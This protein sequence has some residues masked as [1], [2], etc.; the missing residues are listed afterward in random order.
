QEDAFNEL[1]SFGYVTKVDGCIFYYAFGSSED[2]ALIGSRYHRDDQAATTATTNLVFAASVAA[3][4]NSYFAA[5]Q[6]KFSFNIE[7]NDLTYPA[8]LQRIIEDEPTW[9]QRRQS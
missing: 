4:Y 2:C 9:L 6:K 1:L 7:Q 3:N 5:A 8:Y